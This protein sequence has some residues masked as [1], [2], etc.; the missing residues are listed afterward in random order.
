ME[1]LDSTSS[2]ILARTM[3][4]ICRGEYCISF[5]AGQDPVQVPHWKHRFRVS[6]PASM[7]VL[8][9]SGFGVTAIY[10]TSAGIIP[11]G[12][13]KDYVVLPFWVMG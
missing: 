10:I 6:A 5:A 12:I 11:G 13:Y 9:N 1:L 2:R 7:T 3:A 8:V 4:L